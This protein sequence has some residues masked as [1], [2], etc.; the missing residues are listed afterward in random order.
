MEEFRSHYFL[1]YGQ[2]L[3]DEVLYFFIRVNEMQTDL[4]KQIA[5]IPKLTFKSGW[6]Y[7][8]YGLGRLTIPSIVVSLALIIILGLSSGRAKSMD[9][10]IVIKSGAAFLKVSQNDTVYY[11]PVKDIPKQ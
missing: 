10:S 7:F 2:K 4:K 9:G 8:M 3:D 1:N 6:D 5:A 11:L